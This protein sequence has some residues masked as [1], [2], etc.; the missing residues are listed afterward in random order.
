M[1]KIQEVIT[2]MV[3]GKCNRDDRYSSSL[4]NVGL[5]I[6]SMLTY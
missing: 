3:A 6:L 2:L 5:A 4:E 1:F